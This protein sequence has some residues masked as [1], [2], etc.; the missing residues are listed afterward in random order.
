MPSKIRRLPQYKITFNENIQKPSAIDFC[1]AA[2]SI[3]SPLTVYYNVEEE[4]GIVYAFLS[5]QGAEKMY[6]I[7][8][9]WN[10]NNISKKIDMPRSAT[11]FLANHI[12]SQNP[13]LDILFSVGYSNKY[14]SILIICGN[15]RET[16]I[17]EFIESKEK[18]LYDIP[19]ILSLIILNKM[20]IK[21]GSDLTIKDCGKDT[22]VFPSGKNADDFYQEF[23]DLWEKHTYKVINTRDDSKKISQKLKMKSDHELFSLCRSLKLRNVY[24]TAK[25]GKITLKGF[26]EEIVIF[27]R[28]LYGKIG[29]LLDNQEDTVDSIEEVVEE[30]EI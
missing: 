14:E 10:I 17:E 26:D 19:H 1:K 23:Y 27:T 24:F 4:N 7:L 29:V 12:T 9:D 22:L 20:K 3:V 28:A 16:M 18:Y 5:D 13:D 11:A 21:I 25:N 8:N 15:D 2:Q 6:N 30:V